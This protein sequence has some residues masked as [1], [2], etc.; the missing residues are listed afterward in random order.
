[1]VS[2]VIRPVPLNPASH[3]DMGVMN[4]AGIMLFVFMFTG[5]TRIMDR[6]EGCLA[7]LFYLAYL[8]YLLLPVILPGTAGVK[9][10]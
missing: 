1:G 5:R 9:P 3:V 10:G 2:A 8:G 6:W 7:L 4:A